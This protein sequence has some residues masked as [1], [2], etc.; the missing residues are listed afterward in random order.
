MD[1]DPARVAEVLSRP[2]SFYGSGKAKWRVDARL[3]PGTRTFISQQFERDMRV[4]DVGCGDGTTLIEG[5]DR[6]AHGTGIDLDPQH[7]DLARAA[8]QDVEN[9]MFEEAALDEFAGRAEKE[10]FDFV[11]TERGPFG[12]SIDTVETALSLVK[13]GG[14]LFAE[15]IGDLHHSEV[16]AVFGGAQ[17]DVLMSVADQ[18]RVAFNRAGVDVRIA[19]DIVSKRYYPDVYA[20]LEFQC[21]IWAWAGRPFPEPDDPA[22]ELFV[23][24]NQTPDGEIETTHHVTWIGGVK[25]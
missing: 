24:R 9:L 25:R 16:R 15:V 4:L 6:F 1:I 22:L 10:S 19:A 23:D 21:G 12:Y 18:T 20:W 3:N 7:L 17:F 14:L 5:A 8:G 2:H 11:Y 13:P